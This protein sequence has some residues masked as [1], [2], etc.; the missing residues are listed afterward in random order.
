MDHSP[1]S[2]E[3]TGQKLS[4]KAGTKTSRFLCLIHYPLYDF[5]YF[6]GKNGNEKLSSQYTSF[7]RP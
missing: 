1:N 7:K 5:I 2:L 6:L 3:A 4:Q